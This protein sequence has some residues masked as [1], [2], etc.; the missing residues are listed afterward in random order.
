MKSISNGKYELADRDFYRT[1]EKRPNLALVRAL[2][3]K[4]KR[5]YCE[6]FGG[7]GD[8]I[9]NLNEMEPLLKCIQSIDIEPQDKI[10][11]RGDALTSKLLKVDYV[12]S[13]P[14]FSK[15]SKKRITFPAIERMR[16]HADISCWFLLPA[17]WY[18]NG[19]FQP[20]MKYCS[21]MVPIGRF[22]LFE[23]SKDDASFD[24]VW[25]EF[26]KKECD[27]IVK[28]RLT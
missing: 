2:D 27:T 18:C 12:I 23:N 14:P 3:L 26:G 13:N 7:A 28:R 8:I 21:S 20:Y 16:N 1:W 4:E 6:P 11:Q 10:V 15:L 25:Y 17:N 22:K 5:T 19:D 24:L 9:K